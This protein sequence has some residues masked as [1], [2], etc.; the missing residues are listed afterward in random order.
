METSCVWETD[1]EA[2]ESSTATAVV[3][4]TCV[5]VTSPTGPIRFWATAL[6]SVSSPSCMAI[7][8]AKA[9]D[10]ATSISAISF[11]I[12]VYS[13]SVGGRDALAHGFYG[14]V[15]SSGRYRHLEALFRGAS[16][17]SRDLLNQFYPRSLRQPG[18]L[19]EARGFAPPPHDGLAFIVGTS[20]TAR[21]R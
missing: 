20:M 7:A 9:G 21:R 11:F 10:A 19:V 1:A 12:E 13:F 3:V 16:P 8:C 4:P 17:A 14:R 2:A 15:N 5:W 6:N 18:S